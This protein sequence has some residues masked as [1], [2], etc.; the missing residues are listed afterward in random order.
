V[1]RFSSSREA[2]EYT[3]GTIPTVRYVGFAGRSGQGLSQFCLWSWGW[4][5]AEVSSS[6][7]CGAQL[8][9]LT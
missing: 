3:P 4:G 9:P 8:E 2:P 7:R 6:R 5:Q 1:T